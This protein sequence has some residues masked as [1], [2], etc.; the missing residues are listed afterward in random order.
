MESFDCDTKLAGKR[1]AAR[2]FG[3]ACSLTLVLLACVITLADADAQGSAQLIGTWRGTSVCTDRVAA[4]ACHDETVVYEFTPGPR[5]GTVHWT[6]DKVVN[7]QRERM[8]ELDLAYDKASA[9]WKGDF[10]S[11]RF[12]GVWCLSVE[13]ERLW[14]TGRLLPGN[15]TVRKVELRKE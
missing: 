9:C 4:P 11:P 2:R 5:P 6:A 7:G 1:R 8:G 3:A 15:E 13:G 12:R 14:G 10:T